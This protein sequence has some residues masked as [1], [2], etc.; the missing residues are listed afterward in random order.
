MASANRESNHFCLP[1]ALAPIKGI[2]NA[3]LRMPNYEV[4]GINGYTSQFGIKF[5][6]TVPKG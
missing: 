6:Y 5:Q 1:F 2:S 3:E 4:H